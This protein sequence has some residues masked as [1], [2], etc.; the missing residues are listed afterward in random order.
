MSWGI[1]KKI[2][3][4]IQKG[5]NW[6]KNKIIK[7]VI[8]VAKPVVKTLANKV[9]PAVGGAIGAKFGNPAIGAKLGRIAGEAISG[10]GS[11]D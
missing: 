1:W 11:G 2:K 7:P 10:S 8:E 6:V 4:G 3:N 5:A 9:L